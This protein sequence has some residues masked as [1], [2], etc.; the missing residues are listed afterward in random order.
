MNESGRTGHAARVFKKR[1]GDNENKNGQSCP[2]FL[3]SV[4]LNDHIIRPEYIR[5]SQA[6]RYGIS[7]STAYNW[8]A[9]GLV[10][11][12]LV[13]RPGNAKGIRLISVSS[14]RKFI[15]GCPSK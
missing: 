4:N 6:P 12:K 5:P 13:R 2:I 9:D 8:V 3:C 15:E 10:T 11:T 1:S 14:L 7:R